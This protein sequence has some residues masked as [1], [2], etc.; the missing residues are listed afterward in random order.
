MAEEQ[1]QDQP[2][3]Q[4]QELSIHDQLSQ[5][6][7]AA[8]SEGN[9]P[10]VEDT[11]DLNSDDPD[12]VDEP[13]IESDEEISD[14]EE[15]EPDNAAETLEA[16]KL[17]KQSDKEMFAK[18]SK[19][20]QEF[21]LRRYDEMQSDYHAKR[22]E[23]S[24]IY[25]E[26][27]PIH[28]IFKPHINELKMSGTSPA[29]MIYGWSQVYQALQTDPRAALEDLASQ[30]GVD[31][32][33]SQDDPDRAFDDPKYDSLKQE[34]NQLKNSVSQRQQAEISQ[35][36]NTLLQ[37]IQEFSTKKV[38][39]SDELAHPYFDDVVNDMVVLAQVEM[40]KGNTPSIEKLYETAVYSNATTRQKL[41]DSQRK[42]DQKKQQEVARQKAA[43]ARKASGSITNTG[44][45]ASQVVEKSLREELE[46]LW[47]S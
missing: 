9:K 1:I 42:A 8:E 31:L 14:E 23:D 6:F 40:Q 43:K 30:Y 13:E 16:P 39:G 41:L 12:I 32:T 3:V 20:A 27:G 44:A 7:D 25:N 45:G 21:L 17:W 38:E 24:Y 33:Q 4:E 5:A 34:L 18:Q 2:E 36:Q 19:E 22:Q 11:D 15:V 46:S 10:Q 37:D 29:Q 47:P 26:Y 28:E 35:R